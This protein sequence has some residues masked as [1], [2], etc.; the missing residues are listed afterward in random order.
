MA[1]IR[2]ILVENDPETVEAYELAFMELA[3]LG[4]QIYIEFQSILGNMSETPTV[5][6]RVEKITC[7][8]RPHVALVDLGLLGH[9]KEDGPFIP[10]GL[11][12]PSTV[13]RIAAGVEVCKYLQQEGTA[14]IVLSGFLEPE[15]DYYLTTQGINVWEVKG[16]DFQRSTL[17]KILKQAENVCAGIRQF[18]VSWPLVEGV[19]E[20]LAK[21][22]RL[23]NRSTLRETHFADLLCRLF[24]QEQSINLFGLRAHPISKAED[25]IRR[26]PVFRVETQHNKRG[27]V[28][29][30]PKVQ[31]YEE[32]QKYQEFIENRIPGFHAKY[33]RPVH[34]WEVGAIFAGYIG[35]GRNQLPDFMQHYQSL[36]NGIPAIVEPLRHF[37]ELVWKDHYEDTENVQAGNFYSSYTHCYPKFEKRMALFAAGDLKPL[38]RKKYGFLSE[39]HP[40]PVDYIKHNR[41][42]IQISSPKLAVTHGDLHCLNLL[43]DH[44]HSF[45]IDFEFTE[46]GPRLRD[47]AR[48]ETDIYIRLVANESKESKR[49]LFELSSLLMSQ[50]ARTHI[51]EASE[52]I[53]ADPALS[54]A[55]SVLSW[56]RLCMMR[57]T[58]YGD[59]NEY[60]WT[61][62]LEMVYRAGRAKERQLLEPEEVQSIKGAIPDSKSDNKVD[63]DD[64]LEECLLIGAV[65]AKRLSEGV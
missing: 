38:I 16:S 37:F 64:R 40:N 3:D 34:F 21:H 51:P 18:E 5:R 57:A 47:F 41:N 50:T 59:M 60:F 9:P 8:F 54:R 62:L 12:D 22:Q 17:P 29:F 32:Y 56:L 45:I 6:E 65:I 61:L 15:L 13:T 14:T 19:P 23:S 42:Q 31:V 36:G 58:N 20:A 30:A 25:V 27:I 53:L 63:P 2:V 24:D 46:K 11:K 33:N 49:Q 35:Y 26:A 1:C 44:N 48:L 52:F 28:K 4:D 55:Y 10:L 39:T 43:V 7:D